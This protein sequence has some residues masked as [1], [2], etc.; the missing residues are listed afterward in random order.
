MT[1]NKTHRVA[2]GQGRHGSACATMSTTSSASGRRTRPTRSSASGSWARRRRRRRRGRRPAS[3]AAT[4]RRRRSTSPPFA[5]GRR[6]RRTPG[7]AAVHQGRRGPRRRARAD[8]R[9]VRPARGAPAGRG[10]VTPC[11]GCVTP[12]KGCTPRSRAKCRRDR[13]RRRARG[14]QA[15]GTSH[16]RRGRTPR[17]PRE[18]P[19]LGPGA[20][21]CPGSGELD[22]L[23][24]DVAQRGVEVDLRLPP[25]G[26][27][28]AGRVPTEHGDVERASRARRPP[29]TWP[30]DRRAHGGPRRRR[31]SARRSPEH[32]L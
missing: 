24:D 1:E 18:A 22:G 29:R 15:Q 10:E 27:P 2:G 25:G 4:T 13:D 11:S 3:S 14:A 32:T 30:R 20:S 26:V 31:R 19:V 12:G 28:Q 23:G 17:R 8:R 21:S 5:P 16:E 9:G 6:T 7:A